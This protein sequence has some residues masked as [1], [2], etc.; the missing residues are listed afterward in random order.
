MASNFKIIT[1]KCKD[2]LRLK[3]SGDL[4]G[5]SACEVLNYIHS[6]Y[7]DK[8]KILIYGTAINR[9]HPF[10]LHVLQQGLKGCDRDKLEIVLQ[11]AHG[12]QRENESCQCNGRCK[13]CPHN[14]ESR[15]KADAVSADKTKIAS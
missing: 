4:D 9:I 15:G 14:S 5:S 12:H 8:K 11:E 13:N 3:L 6:Y 10:G 2:T 1:D 7:P